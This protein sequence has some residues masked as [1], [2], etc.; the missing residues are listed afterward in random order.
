MGEQR[1]ERREVEFLREGDEGM[2]WME[3]LRERRG[4]EGLRGRE[5]FWIGE[6]EE[7]RELLRD[8]EGGG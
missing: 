8:K 7:A 6:L 5:G 4:E 1:C 2:R 3:G